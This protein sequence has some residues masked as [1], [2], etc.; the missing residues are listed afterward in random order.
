M[1]SRRLWLVPLILTISIT[2]KRR[3]RRDGLENQLPATLTDWRQSSTNT[4]GRYSLPIR[5]YNLHRGLR[6]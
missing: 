1:I 5:R 6:R 3:E 2:A 4:R